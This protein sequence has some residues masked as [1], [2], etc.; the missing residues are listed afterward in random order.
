LHE[1]VALD[2]KFA[3]ERNAAGSGSRIVWVVDSFDLLDLAFGVVFDHDLERPKH[4]HSS[5]RGLIQDFANAELEH[6]PVDHAVGFGNTD[7][8]DEFA[9]RRR[10]YPAPSEPRDGGHARIVPSGHMAAA[11]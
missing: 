10:W 1:I 3:A 2:V 5:K 9:D 7:A 4:R 6:S 8:F 11:N